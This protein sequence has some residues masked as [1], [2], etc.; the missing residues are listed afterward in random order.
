MQHRGA[1]SGW[2]EYGYGIGWY[3]GG[4]KYRAPYSATPYSAS[5]SFHLPPHTIYQNQSYYQAINTKKGNNSR[6]IKTGKPSFKKIP[7][8]Y[9]FEF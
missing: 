5:P 4:V 3:P 7:E 9:N 1:I 6:K 2:I 8:K